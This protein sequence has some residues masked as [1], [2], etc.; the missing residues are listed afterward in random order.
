MIWPEFGA[1]L[2]HPSGVGALPNGRM[3]AMTHATFDRRLKALGRKHERMTLGITYRIGRDGLITA[4][5]RRRI[6]PRFPL[7]SLLALMLAAFAFKAA[8]FVLLGEQTYGARLALLE[9]GDASIVSFNMTEDDIVR[10]VRQPWTMTSS[11]GALVAFGR[12][13]PHP[14]GNGAFSRKLRKYVVE[15]RV[16]GLAGAIR[17]MTSRFPIRAR[18]T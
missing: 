4:H 9:Q 15:E 2:G 14:R 12:G 16:V 13:V 18:Y 5:P 8:L 3:T 7:R 6:A 10:L 11:D 17:S 1:T